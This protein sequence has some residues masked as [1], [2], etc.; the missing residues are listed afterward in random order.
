MAERL[1]LAPLVDAAWSA[2][3]NADK[4]RCRVEP[5]API[6]FFGDLDEYR[7]SPLRIVTVGLNP[8]VREFPDRARFSRFPLAEGIEGRAPGR[9]IDALCAYYRTDPYRMWFGHFERFLNGAEASY[10]E[11]REATALHTDICSPIAT[12]PTWRQLPE[13]E[14]AALEADGLPLWHA[15]IEALA[16]RIVTLSVARDHLE[17]I[18]F[19][20]QD[21][22]WRTIREFRETDDGESRSPYLVETRWYR[23]DGESTLF[24]FCPAGRVPMMI[25]R[26]QKLDAA[27]CALEVFADGPETIDS[28]PTPRL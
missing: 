12:D 15:L 5:A 11:G 21:R 3:D 8:S 19:E 28:V 13:V 24:V 27:S 14:Q 18:E 25:G 20:P 23:V 26:K 22:T 16:P 6:L 4:L 10:Y 7:A 2:Y 1:A 9:Y 17:K